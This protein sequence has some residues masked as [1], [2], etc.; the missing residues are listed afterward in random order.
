MDT[1]LKTKNPRG[2]PSDYCQMILFK[3]TTSPSGAGDCQSSVQFTVK[4]ETERKPELSWCIVHTDLVGCSQL[5]PITSHISYQKLEFSSF[6]SGKEGIKKGSG[7]N[8]GKA[9]LSFFQFLPTDWHVWQS[10]RKKKKKNTPRG[11]SKILSS[12]ASQSK[13]KK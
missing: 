7:S 3:A 1:S 12:I 5:Q 9:I 13:K 2:Q 8:W 6:G 11:L 4:K 10:D